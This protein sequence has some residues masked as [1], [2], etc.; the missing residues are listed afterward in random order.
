LLLSLLLTSTSHAQPLAARHQ[1]SGLNSHFNFSGNNFAD[2]LTQTRDMIARARLDLND[3]NRE[4]IITANQPFELLPAAECPKPATQKRFQRGILLIHGLSDSPYWLRHLGDFLQQQCFYVLTIL[5]PGNGTRPGDLLEVSWQDWAKAVNFGAELLNQTVEQTW[6]GGY[7]T[8]AT[9]ALYQASRMPDIKGLLLFSPALRLTPKA[10]YAHWRQWFGRF[11]Q[12]ALWW[13]VQ[14]DEDPYKYESFPINGAVQLYQLI[15]NL[16]PLLQQTPAVPLFIAASED[17]RS[18]DSRATIKLFN[19]WSH[20]DKKL[21]WFSREMQA[22]DGPL[23]IVDSRATDAF[24]H[25]PIVSSSHISLLLPAS[26]RH[27][28]ANGSNAYCT[29][30]FEEQPQAWQQC[31]ARNE[32]LLGETTPYFL[33][34]GV[35]RRLTYNPYYELMLQ[36]VKRFIQAQ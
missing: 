25:H 34:Q 33:S 29:H 14:P 23:Q 30:Y 20:A 8:G 15:Q 17:D 24:S 22:Q 6:L 32:D 18:V 35:I 11:W 13:Q 16:Q 28:G 12:P 4:D 9:L 26:D 10:A 36:E 1:P 3:D 21:L 5:L 7:S 19:Q 2:Y 31:K 27:Y